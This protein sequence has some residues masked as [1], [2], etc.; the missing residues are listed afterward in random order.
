MKKY[1]FIALFVVW[2]TVSLFVRTVGLESSPASMG[3]DEA[4]LGYNAYSILLTGKDEY[5]TRF[6]LS[7]RSFNDFKPALYAYLA[8]PFIKYFGL[9]QTSTRLPSAVF[10]TLSL[11]FLYLIFKKLSG[12]SNL[13]SLL[14]IAFVSFLPWELH[15]SRVALEANVSMSFFTGAVWCLIN[16]KRNKFYKIGLIFF[17]TLSI[18]SYHSARVAIPVLVFLALVDPISLDLK[19]FVKM[20]I[21]TIK[22]LW[23]LLIILILYIPLFLEFQASLI[24]TRLGQTNIFSH[25][26]P[27]TPRELIFMPNA[28]LNIIGHPLYFLGGYITGHLF[29]YL[30]PQN[31]SL[32][33]YPGV[34]N[35]DQVISGTGMLGTVGGFLFTIGLV[36][37][38]KEIVLD[39]NKRII[40]YWII[41]GII[42]AAIT[43]EWF[44]PLRSLNIY[45]AINIIVGFGIVS[46]LTFLVKRK[47]IFKYFLVSAFVLIMVTTS[48]YNLLNELNFGAW[49]T[50]GEFQP[51]GFKQAVPLILSL[52]NEYKM[53]Y[54]DSNQGQSY[55]IF[56]F[57]MH[58]S[59]SE[60]QKLSS[61]RN[62]P[63]VEGPSTINFGK[64]IYKKFDW[65]HDKYKDS[66]IYFT[67]SEVKEDEIAST[68]GSKL[69][70]IFDQTGNWVASVITKQ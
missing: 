43:W 3:F 16:F 13:M 66:F 68:Q 46:V 41:S 34:I 44:Y 30:S 6:P 36:L 20:P 61:I 24:L 50:G 28:W 18:Y 22:K 35:S 19:K 26:Y 70:K 52:Q 63:G 5:G 32:L 60:I 65:P 55:E 54:L 23:P 49:E 1:I 12:R 29:S 56:W 15:F 38:L 4:S 25:F 37:Q 51:G 33:I 57:Y 9:S 69:Y 14:V 2:A 53:I 47:K 11:I 48:L 7:L 17:S 39:K 58:Y 64:F 8:I 67:N 40:S 10:G 27:F 62:D 59:P 42:P 45:P 21:N 31:L